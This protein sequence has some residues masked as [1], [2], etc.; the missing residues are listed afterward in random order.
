MEEN[1]LKEGYAMLILGGSAGSLAVIFGLLPLLKPP[2]PFAIVLVLHRKNASD[3][4]L[5]ELLSLKTSIPVKEVEDKDP[6]TP[7]TIYLAPSDYHLLIEK[8]GFFALD[9][10]E[11]V[12]Y[13]RPSIDVTLESAADAYGSK[14]IAILLSGANEDGTLGLAAVKQAGGTIIAQDPDSAQIAV[15]PRHAI[16]YNAMDHIL[17]TQAIGTFILE[18]IAGRR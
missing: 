1:Q 8:N 14:L 11:K 18:L 4:S 10:S 9:D 7:G 6:I 3:S 17:S 15:M 2:V 13:S 16:Q 5:P 12:Q